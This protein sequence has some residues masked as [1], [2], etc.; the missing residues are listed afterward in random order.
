MCG[1]TFSLRLAVAAARSIILANPAVVN[2]PPL[3]DEHKRAGLVLALQAAKRSHF[4]SGQ[5]VDARCALLRPADV[6]DRVV[7]IN[8]IP[9]KFNQF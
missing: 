9:T 7:E 6:K 2:G 8:L 3:A 5:W 4:Q 1:W